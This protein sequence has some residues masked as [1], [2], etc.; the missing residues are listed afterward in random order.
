M[1]QKPTYKWYAVY[2]RPHNEKKVCSWLKENNIECYLPLKSSLRQWSDRKKWIEE[3]LF[4]S[5]IF[6]RVSYIEYF[7]VL[8]IPGVV[9]YVSFGGQPQAI[10]DNQI[11]YIKII[12]QQRDQEIEVNYKNIRKGS[13]CEVLFGPL[14]GIRGEVVR[15]SG[16]SR[17]VIRLA[18]MGVSLQVNISRDEIKPIK[19]QKQITQQNKYSSLNNIP[20]R[21]AQRVGNN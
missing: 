4:R 6:V 1:L 17:L 20:Y 3:P 2:T 10:P 9:K 18:S 7:N 5:Y 21:K 16:Q 12:V 15:I 8:S 11:E 19:N 14:K 13:E